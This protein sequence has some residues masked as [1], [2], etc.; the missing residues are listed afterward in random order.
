MASL[1]FLDFAIVAG[2]ML[3]MMGLGVV[4][5]RRGGDFTDFFLAGRAL[6]TP[7]LIASLVSTY[8]GIDVLFGTSQLAYSE[9]V[10]AWF[11]YSRVGYFVILVMVFGL[12]ERLKREDYTSLPDVMGRFYDDRSRYTSAAATFM[13]SVPATSLYGFGIIG[14]VLLGWPPVLSMLLF[15]S[16]ALVYTLA[17][18]IYAVAFTDVIQFVLMCVL[19]A[20]AVPLALGLIGGFDAMFVNLEPTYFEHMGDMSLGLLLIYASTHLA[21]LVEPSFYQRIFA[22]RSFKAARNAILIG[23][24]LWGA[25][26][27]VVTVLGMAART[28]VLQGA[29]DPGIAGD[30]SLA[31]LLFAVLPVGLLGLFIAGVLAA[32]MST[33]DSYCLVAG[34]SLCY[35]IYRPLFNRKA[36]EAML[37]RGTRIGILVAWCVGFTM[38]SSFGQ[39]LGLWVFMASFLI[40]TTLAPI[41]FGLYIPAWR[42]PL[43]GFLSS[44]LGLST[45]IIANAII[46]LVGHYSETKATY[47]LE[48]H[49]FDRNWTLLQEYIMFLSVPL[50]L[51]GFFLGLILDKRRA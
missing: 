2:Y 45:V 33:M 11:G 10:V 51:L 43:A 47:V 15:G 20:V 16:V 44:I 46:V 38:A 30:H 5:A 17:G 21:A 14:S 48:V 12:A 13:Y 19:L 1:S 39:L 23:I 3:L 34:G 4:L 7:I 36:S 31:H 32:Q 49:F 24:V 8:Y 37:I 26:D 29:L 25:Y 9:G 18:G 42:R 6:T 22:A 40:S 41:L 28:A 27:W 35:D 50:S